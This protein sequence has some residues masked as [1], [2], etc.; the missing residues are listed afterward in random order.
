MDGVPSLNDGGNVL[1]PFTAAKLALRLPPSVDPGKA[2]EALVSALSADPPQGAQ[3]AV[4]VTNASAGFDAPAQA[5]WLER[6]TDEASEAFFG[7]R[8][9]AM[10]EGGTIPFLAELLGRF[11]Q[12]QFLVTGVLGPSSNAHG[13]NEMLDL[14]TARR[15]TAAVAYVLASAP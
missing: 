14:V 7:R 2:A 11:P 4:E 9:G 15:L 13:P 10:S 12:A 1:R 8:A 5:E 6:A 3:V